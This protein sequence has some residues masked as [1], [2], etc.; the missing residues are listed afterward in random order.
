M[1]LA[2]SI[3]QKVLVYSV[4]LA[5]SLACVISYI[6]C[7]FC[8]LYTCSRWRKLWK[9]LGLQ[10]ENICHRCSK[11]HW[12]RIFGFWRWISI[13]LQVT[14]F[15]YHYILLNIKGGLSLKVRKFWGIF[16]L[17]KKG[18]KNYLEILWYSWI[19]WI[20]SLN[21]LISRFYN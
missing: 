9:R 16:T 10:L 17:P 18:V 6:Y 19:F 8:N 11:V 1:A 2:I 15:Y 20:Y 14:S 5:C 13:F 21:L 4:W 7:S 3:F 12:I